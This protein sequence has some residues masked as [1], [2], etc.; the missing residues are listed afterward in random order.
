MCIEHSVDN[1]IL[2]DLYEDYALPSCLWSELK[3]VLQFQYRIMTVAEKFIDTK[4]YE[5]RV[6]IILLIIS[7]LYFV[8]LYMIIVL[9]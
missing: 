9:R 3:I 8:C 1:L 2:L 5:E 4:V 6:A 7:V